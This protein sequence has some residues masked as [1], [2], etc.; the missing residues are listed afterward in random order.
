MVIALQVAVHLPVAQ[1]VEV[2]QADQVV[3]QAQQDQQ[4]HLLVLVAVLV[5]Q[6][7]QQVLLA[8]RVLLAEQALRVRQVVQV[9]R[10]PSGPMYRVTLMLRG[11]TLEQEMEQHHD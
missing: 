4:G 7:V 2:V 5:E 9:Q 6:A 11:L 1:V 10:G 3:V 8:L